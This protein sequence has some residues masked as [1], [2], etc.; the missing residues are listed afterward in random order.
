[1]N[2]DAA[3][4]LWLLRHGETQWTLTGR[5]TGRTDVRLT[6]RGERQAL[7]LGRRLA[8]RSFSLVLT[9]PRARARETCRLAGYGAAAVVAPDMQEWDYGAY[10]GKTTA[11][12][13]KAAPSW[14][15]WTDGVPDGETP[16]AVGQRADLMIAQA[17]KA[18]G[19]V[20][21]FAHGHFLRVLA[22]RWL[23]LPPR[24]GGS[25]ALDT[26]SVSLLGFERERRV[27]RHW[28]E[29]CHLEEDA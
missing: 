14:T 1:M 13:R 17:M 26:A 21:L 12:I 22:A 20:A 2:A 18:G 8:G 16:D 28:N 23:G 15:V 25:L 5:H 24:G 6:P 29:V 11:E 10:E 3:P 7:A 27:I 4:V 9:S 19:H